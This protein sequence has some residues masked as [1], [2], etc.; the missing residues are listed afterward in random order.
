MKQCRKNEIARKHREFKPSFLGL[1]NGESSL[2][3]LFMVLRYPTH[4]YGLVCF[5][6]HV[7]VDFELLKLSQPKQGAGKNQGSQ[8]NKHVSKQRPQRLCVLLLV[9]LMCELHSSC[10]GVR[11][12]NKRW[13]PPGEFRGNSCLPR[14]SD[15]GH[16]NEVQSSYWFSGYLNPVVQSHLSHPYPLTL[17]WPSSI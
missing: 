10:V 12:S 3:K 6:P 9:S 8:E 14:N 4:G 15:Q 11:R 7:S 17:L 16:Y 13:V 1:C 5:T 2:H